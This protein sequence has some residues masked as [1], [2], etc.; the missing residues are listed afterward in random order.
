MKE[1]LK[2]LLNLNLILIYI[3]VLTE[4]VKLIVFC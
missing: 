1:N 2:F 3:V 4:D